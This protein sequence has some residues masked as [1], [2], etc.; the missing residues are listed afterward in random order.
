MA[1][2]VTFSS[3]PIVA[4]YCPSRTKTSAS[5]DIFLAEAKLNTQPILLGVHEDSESMRNFDRLSG[6]QIVNRFKHGLDPAHGSAHG[7][8]QPILVTHPVTALSFFV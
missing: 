5:K 3:I 8:R 7:P 4:H 2:P 6:L 1:G